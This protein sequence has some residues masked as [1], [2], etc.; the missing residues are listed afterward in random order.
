MSILRNNV[1]MSLF[2]IKICGVT[3]PADAASIA[4]AGADAIGLNFYSASPRFVDDDR[5]AEIIA[6][7]PAHVAKVGVFVNAD[8]ATIRKKVERLGLDWV[9]LHGD[10]PPEFVAELPGLAVIRAVR[11]QD[12]ASVLL[13]A[14]KGKLIRLPKAVLIDAY[15]ASAYGGTGTTVAWEA[16][17]GAKNR[18]AGLPVILAGGLTPE[19]VAEAIQMARPDAVDTA[20][21]VESSPGIKDLAKVREFVAAARAGWGARESP[22]G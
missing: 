2:R 18:L 8:A 16:V 17:P 10:E 4:D 14:S 6:A 22:G 21:G 7:L 11:L 1:S 15:S 9:Q 3:R 13:P 12:W 19:N 20:S 5:A